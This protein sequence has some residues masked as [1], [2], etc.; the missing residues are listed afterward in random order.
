[1]GTPAVFTKLL[2]EN[3]LSS[4]VQQAIDSTLRPLAAAVGATPIMGAPAPAW[5]ATDLL[6]GWTNLNATNAAFPPLG[7][8]KDALGYVHLRGYLV[9]GTLNVSCAVL[10][11]MYRPAFR[12]TFPGYVF[13]GASTTGDIEVREDGN[14]VL[15]VPALT[16]N[17]ALDSITFLAEQ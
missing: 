4:R 3:E 6:N 7:Y 1:M 9:A 12:L 17:V 5:R 8:H 2:G 13:N 16:T 10:P 14:I 11:P 15:L